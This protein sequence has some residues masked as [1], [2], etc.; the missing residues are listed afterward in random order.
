MCLYI[1]KNKSKIAKKDIPIWKLV[2]KLDNGEYRG[3]FQ[4]SFVYEL[5][6]EYKADIKI[7][8]IA[9]SS[10]YIINEGIHSFIDLGMAIEYSSYL[11]SSVRSITVLT[12]GIIP[13][14]SEYYKGNYIIST[15][16]LASNRLIITKD[17][18]LVPY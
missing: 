18:G 16:E 11:D 5:N 14:G 1:N 10:S 7:Q 6:K 3:L 2:V 13:K 17:L 8:N 4:R 12:E 15:G 9:G